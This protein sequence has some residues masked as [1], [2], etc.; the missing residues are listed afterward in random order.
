VIGAG[1]HDEDFIEHLFTASTHDYMMFF[2]NNGRVY[3]EKVYDI[4][5]GTRIA[6]GRAV[7]N[8][9]Q[10]QKDETIAA[11]IPVKDLEEANKH[12]VMATSKGIVKKTKLSD[13]KNFR[14]GGIIGINIDEGD[15]LI[16][17]Q[18]TGGEDD[19]VMITRKGMSIRFGESDLRDQ[20]RATRGVKGITLK[21]KDDYVVTIEVVDGDSTLFI[22][23]ANGQ[24]KR[25][26]F[27]EYRKQGRGG[28]GIIAIK[29]SGV[30]G[31]LSVREED[32]IMLL[33]KGGQAVR[34]RV[35]EARI[36]GRTTMGVR[37]IN[38]AKKDKL[39][40]VSK[41]VNVDEEEA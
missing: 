21:G 26:E 29:T 12:L 9:L 33:T 16:G 37:M 17:V 24:G 20:G 2:M 13:Y 32:E 27:S 8:V 22:A 1:Q 15:H 10:M 35:N 34:T 3:V 28:S 31:A 40:G 5:E 41:V 4:P 11:M 39:I 7:V 36:I 38:L 23:G 14:K 30:A 18:L 19:L 6:K 25:T